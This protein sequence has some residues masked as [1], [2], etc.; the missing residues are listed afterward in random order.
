MTHYH[1]EEAYEL[2]LCMEDLFNTFS[3][4]FAIFDS[5]L[6]TIF[7]IPSLSKLQA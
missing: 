6:I 2:T 5:E 3:D 4:A 7:L 1:L